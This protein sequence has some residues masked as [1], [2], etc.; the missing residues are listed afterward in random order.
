MTTLIAGIGSPILGDDAVGVHIARALA[1]APLPPNVSVEIVG[2][3]GL[4]LLDVVRNHRRLIL[5]D[6]IVTGVHSAGTIQILRGDAVVEAVHCGVGHDVDLL[7][8]LAIGREL[9]GYHMPSEVMAVAVEAAELTTFS[10]SLTPAVARAIPQAIQT[11]RA[12]TA[13]R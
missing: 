10:E 6:A 8:V 13:S 11:V 1:S 5:L 12:L 3:G 4:A 7:Q 2:T 9:L